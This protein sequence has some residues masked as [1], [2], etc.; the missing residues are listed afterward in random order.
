M[1]G[2]N[3]KCSFCAK[4]HKNYECEEF[5]NY[6]VEKRIEQAKGNKS[7]LNCLRP[8]HFSRQCRL[9]GSCKKCYAKHNTLL[10]DM[11]R[12]QKEN[13]DAQ[14]SRS[15]DNL[16]LTASHS[17]FTLLSTVIVQIYDRNKAVH[18]VRAILDFGSMSCFISQSLCKKLNLDLQK[19]EFAVSGI[20]IQLNNIE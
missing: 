19:I 11:K 15:N 5:K 8:G 4:S 12:E 10:H 9:S 7:C 17:S 6:P 16:A 20:G 3:S 14:Q 18:Q 2:D 13:N 1:E